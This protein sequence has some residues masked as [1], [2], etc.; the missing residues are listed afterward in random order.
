MNLMA[1]NLR[2][3][4]HTMAEQLPE[5]ASIEDVIERLRFLRAVEEGKRAA[6]RGEFASDEEVRRVFAK[7]GLEA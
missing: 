1:A 3:T 2:E 5:D 4:L 7:Y 6:D